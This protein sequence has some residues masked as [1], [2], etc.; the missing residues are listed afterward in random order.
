[1]KRKILEFT[2]GNSHCWL[3][4]HGGKA[5]IMLEKLWHLLNNL[6]VCDI[7]MHSLK[8]EYLLYDLLI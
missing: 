8:T 7:N 2:A 5:K 4:K 3:G 6:G 1:M